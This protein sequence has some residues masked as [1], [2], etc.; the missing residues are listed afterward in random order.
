MLAIMSPR[1]CWGM[2]F[3]RVNLHRILPPL[4][5]ESFNAD[6]VPFLLP[7]MLLMA[8]QASQLEYQ[9]HI[10]P[11]L[12]PLFKLQSPVQVTTLLSLHV[13]YH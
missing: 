12:I 1:L 9:Q 10:L 2:S 8:Q 7:T 4:V 6:M 11:A 13:C 3:Q 5:K